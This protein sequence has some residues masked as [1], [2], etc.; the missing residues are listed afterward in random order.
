MKKIFDERFEAEG[1]TSRN[2]WYSELPLTEMGEFGPVINLSSQVQEEIAE[3]VNQTISETES[4]ENNFYFYDSETNQDALDEPI[5]ISLMIREKNG[6]FIVHFNMTD[7][8]FAV[9]LDS[10]LETQKSLADKLS[11]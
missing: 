10:T 5:R 2:I 9:N 7:H 6:Q 11:S 3:L 8:N 4:T 1:K